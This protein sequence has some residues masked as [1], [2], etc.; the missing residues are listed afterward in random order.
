MTSHPITEDR[1]DASLDIARAWGDWL[2]LWRLCGNSK[3]QRARRCRGDVK[4][5]LPRNYPLLP[6]GVRGSF[7]C[8]LV[9]RDDAMPF[10]EALL[11]LEQTPGAATLR[12]WHA[13]VARSL[14]PPA[15]PATDM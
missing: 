14:A 4:R 15:A 2:H 12:D 7:E 6:D 13:A 5:C 9:A 1:S 11:Q 8:L 10:E 3:C